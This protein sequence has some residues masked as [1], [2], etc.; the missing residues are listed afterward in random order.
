M[1]YPMLLGGV[2]A[3]AVLVIASF[4]VAMYREKCC[5]QSKPKSSKRRRQPSI[6]SKAEA[7]ITYDIPTRSKA[8]VS[9]VWQQEDNDIAHEVKRLYQDISASSRPVLFGSG[10]GVFLQEAEAFDACNRLNKEDLGQA[11][12]VKER[13]KEQIDQKLS[14]GQ[15]EDVSKEGLNV[16]NINN[17]EHG[18]TSSKLLENTTITKVQDWVNSSFQ[19]VEKNRTDIDNDKLNASSIN[20]AMLPGLKIGEGEGLGL[21]KTENNTDGEMSRRLENGTV[22]NTDKRNDSISNTVIIENADNVCTAVMNSKVNTASSGESTQ[23]KLVNYGPRNQSHTGSKAKQ[24]MEP[25]KLSSIPNFQSSADVKTLLLTR[26]VDHATQ[27]QQ[28][29]RQ[30][31]NSFEVAEEDSD[32]IREQDSSNDLQY[33]DIDSILTSVSRMDEKRTHKLKETKFYKELLTRQAK[34]KIEEKAEKVAKADGFENRTQIGSKTNKNEEV[35]KTNAMKEEDTKLSKSFL[36]TPRDQSLQ[37]YKVRNTIDTRFKRG[38]DRD[39]TMENTRLS[40]SES[41]I[42]DES[43]EHSRSSLSSDIEED[44]AFRHLEKQRASL[45]NSMTHPAQ[46]EALLKYSLVRNFSNR[47]RPLV[48]VSLTHIQGLNLLIATDTIITVKMRLTNDASSVQRSR[49][50]ACS[51][52]IYIEEMFAVEGSSTKNIL[53]DSLTIE[54]IREDEMEAAAV[55]SLDLKGLREKATLLSTVPLK[56]V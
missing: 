11:K 22:C 19:K 50:I 48:Y 37:L 38:N 17:L 41:E 4:L 24:T 49:P 32:V 56:K 53:N 34:M 30:K 46:S 9:S 36:E 44:S 20:G 6:K 13:D 47:F 28:Q 12:Q 2:S 40:L 25:L 51:S 55:V 18:Q 29:Q 23:N 27:Q 43:T 42:A 5:G 45:F 39:V 31:I 3:L 16:V 54:V 10:T 21:A 1:L 15:T 35:F 14:Q 26:W 7:K 33:E 52:D 8:M